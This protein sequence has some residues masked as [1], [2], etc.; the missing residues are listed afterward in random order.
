MKK[1]KASRRFFRYTGKPIRA[2]RETPFAMRLQAR[3]TLDVICFR[4][5]R[6]KLEEAINQALISNDVVRFRELSER[7]KQFIWE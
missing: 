7:Y 1:E 5:N 3:L 6:E 4:Y 2:R